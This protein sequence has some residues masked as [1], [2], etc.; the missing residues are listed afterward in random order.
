MICMFIIQ[1]QDETTAKHTT[2][3]CVPGDMQHLSAH[4]I[5]ILIQLHLISKTDPGG[6]DGGHLAAGE[7]VFYCFG[8]KDIAGIMEFELGGNWRDFR[9]GFDSRDAGTMVARTLPP[10]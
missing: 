6:N 7:N 3:R 2:K 1:P 4:W 8:G 10:V 5:T 9:Q